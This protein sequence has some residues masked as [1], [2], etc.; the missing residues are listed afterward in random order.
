MIKYLLRITQGLSGRGWME[1]MSDL[2][3]HI[4]TAC[5]M[6]GQLPTEM[7]KQEGGQGTR[8]IS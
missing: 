6:D 5:S 7:S 2:R 1:S 8:H 4:S 3:V